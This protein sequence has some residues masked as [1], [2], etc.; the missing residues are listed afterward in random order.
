MITEDVVPGPKNSTRSKLAAESLCELIHL[1]SPALLV[2]YR[3]FFPRDDDKPPQQAF[4][5][6]ILRHD[7]SIDGQTSRYLERTM[8]AL[9]SPWACI[10]PYIISATTLSLLPICKKWRID[11]P[12]SSQADAPSLRSSIA[13]VGGERQQS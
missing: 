5:G 2:C 12:R 4:D 13:G 11:A 1:H 9:K 10:W 7:S 8:L 3:H 6:A